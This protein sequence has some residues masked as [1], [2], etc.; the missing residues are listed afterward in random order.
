M[1]PAAA[2]LTAINNVEDYCNIDLAKLQIPTDILDDLAVRFVLNMPS[3]EKDDPIRICF[4][5]EI[6]FWF[7]VDFYCETFPN[8]PRLKLKRFAY[9]MFTYIPR[10]RKFLDVFD[11]VRIPRVFM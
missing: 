10:L 4:Q 11:Q 6:A 9:I 7:Y 5:V 1:A 3:E 2:A 8:L